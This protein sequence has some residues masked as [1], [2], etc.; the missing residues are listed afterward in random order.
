MREYHK[1]RYCVST[2]NRGLMGESIIQN[3][4]SEARTVAGGK[5]LAFFL[6]GEEYDIEILNVHEIIGVI[7]VTSVPGTPRYIRG[8][9]NLRGKIIP[10]V[11]LRQK[12]GM[13]SKHLTAQTCIIVVNVHGAEIGIIVDRVSEVLSIADNEIE[14]AP[15]FGKDIRTDYL[16]GIGTS[17]QRVRILLDTDRV[18]ADDS[19][20]QIQGSGTM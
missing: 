12:F 10:I 19:P 15:A 20:I 13:E 6:A 2:A 3:A 16:L 5:F 9:A 4:G 14:P 8:I 1:G 11:D 7:P 18:L 17:Q